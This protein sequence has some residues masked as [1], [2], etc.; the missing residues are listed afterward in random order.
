MPLIVDKAE[1]RAMVA[2]VAF[3]LVADTGLGSLTFRQVADATGY[4]TAIVT[5][6]FADKNDLLFEVYRIANHRA[7]DLLETAFDSGEELIDVVT[8]VLPI[9]EEMQRNWR[10]WMAF[11]ALSHSDPTFREET[12]ENARASVGLYARMLRNHFR[13]LPQLDETSV[14]DLARRLIATVGG[15][16]MQACLAPDDWPLERLRAIIAA[17]IAVLDS[18]AGLA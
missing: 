8:R 16:G 7:M 17:E 12:A 1:R 5:N 10:V 6:Y 3:D 9:T 14:D 13:A 15:A 11:W 2:R 18:E 4:S